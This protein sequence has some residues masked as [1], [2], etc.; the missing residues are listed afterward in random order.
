MTDVYRWAVVGENGKAYEVRDDSS[1]A[2]EA[3]REN[4]TSLLNNYQLATG[5]RVARFKLVECA[6]GEGE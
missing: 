4:H 6:E 1:S 5:Y 3:F 2:I